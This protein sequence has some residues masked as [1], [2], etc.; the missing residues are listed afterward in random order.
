MTLRSCDWCGKEYEAKTKRSRYCSDRCRLA[1]KKERDRENAVA[2]DVPTP[3][4]VR[5]E[6]TEDDIAGAVVQLDGCR[7]TFEAGSHLAPVRVRPMCSRM[8]DGLRDLMD[9]EGL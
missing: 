9:G 6:V 3:L 5:P 1:A 2:I 8:A 7:S 4:P